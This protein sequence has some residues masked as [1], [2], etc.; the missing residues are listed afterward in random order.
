M[1]KSDKE[2]VD[3]N[4][5]KTPIELYEYLDD[6]ESLINEFLIEHDGE[7]WDLLTNCKSRSEVD[8]YIK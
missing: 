5:F 8:F 1:D 7:G 4:M 3:N 2:V 6:N